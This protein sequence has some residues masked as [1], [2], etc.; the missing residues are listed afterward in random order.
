MKTRVHVDLL[1]NAYTYLNATN[2]CRFL[3]LQLSHHFVARYTR[4][5]WPTHC[6]SKSS[7][8]MDS[9][10]VF[11]YLDFLHDGGLL[12]SVAMTLGMLSSEVYCL[13]IVADNT[14]LH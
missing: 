11:F 7:L 1:G 14:W 6:L 12:A 2:S 13:G 8:S 4:A 5:V 10:Y 3:F 9:A